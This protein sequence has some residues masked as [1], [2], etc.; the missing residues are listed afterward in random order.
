[1]GFNDPIVAGNVLVIPAIRSPNFVSGTSGWTINRDGSAEFA[2][3]VVTGGE[4]RVT[5][6]DGSYVRVYDQ[7]PGDGAVIEMNPATIPT[8][9]IPATLATDTIGVDGAVLAVT[10]PAVGGVQASGLA[11]SSG[12]TLGRKAILTTDDFQYQ[13]SNDINPRSLG[14]NIG[15]VNMVTPPADTEAGTTF[16]LIA[17]ATSLANFRKYRAETDL[18]IC[19]D[20]PG[21]AT[22][23]GTRGIFGLRHAGGDITVG[24]VLYSSP[25]VENHCSAR[26]R[27][28]GLAAGLYTFE[29]I[30]R[31]DAAGAAGTLTINT[32][33]GSLSYEVREVIS[34]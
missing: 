12:N 8:S 25:S 33:C 7:N 16:Q 28:T 23:G 17:G 2:D 24:A 30:W 27:V 11:L 1:M 18:V 26:V 6:P 22:L 15:V 32:A 31:R 14:F 29:P 13:T 9:V 3:L 20:H 10:G 21:F 5:D 19:Q 34:P 4:F